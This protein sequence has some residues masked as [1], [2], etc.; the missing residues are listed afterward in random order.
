MEAKYEENKSKESQR[1]AEL[2]EDIR[3]LIDE[4]ETLKKSLSETNSFVAIL[5]NKINQLEQEALNEDAIK[6]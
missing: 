6:K 4:N 1:I 2:N 5:K 3:N